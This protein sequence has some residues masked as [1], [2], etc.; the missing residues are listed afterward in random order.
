MGCAVVRCKGNRQVIHCDMAT[1]RHD[2]VHDI[3]QQAPGET[4]STSSVQQHVEEIDE[5]PDGASTTAA[6]LGPPLPRE[7]SRFSFKSE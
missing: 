5:Q 4:E 6:G 2:Q 3:E 7:E 1:R